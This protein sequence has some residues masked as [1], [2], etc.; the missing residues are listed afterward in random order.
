[1]LSAYLAQQLQELRSRV[2]GGED[3]ARETRGIVG[4]GQDQIKELT[5][6]VAYLSAIVV[7]LA[8]ILRDQ[9]KI[10]AE[11]INSKIREV[12]LRGTTVQRQSK[13]CGAC[14]LVSPPECRACKFC[15]AP[16]PD[17]KLVCEGETAPSSD[18]ITRRP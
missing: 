1:M 9:H 16:L 6:Q 3:K 13:R 14:G 5:R 7:A 15:S 8:E 10:P 4:D 18:A 2:D 11:L 12:E 17:D